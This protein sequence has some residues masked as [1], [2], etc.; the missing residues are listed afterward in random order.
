MPYDQTPNM[1]EAGQSVRGVGF[2]IPG[3]L[4]RPSLHTDDHLATLQEISK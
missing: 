3:A 2:A 4:L 1:N